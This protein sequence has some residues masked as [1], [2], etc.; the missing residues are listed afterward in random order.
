MRAKLYEKYY[1]RGFDHF[2]FKNVLGLDKPDKSIKRLYYAI[3]TAVIILGI[4]VL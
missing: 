3:I 4:T 1:K 2:I